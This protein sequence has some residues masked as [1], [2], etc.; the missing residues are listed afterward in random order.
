MWTCYRWPVTRK[1][2][3]IRRNAAGDI[4]CLSHDAKG[5]LTRSLASNCKKDIAQAS[6]KAKPRVCT[7][8]NYNTPLHWCA[9]NQA[10]CE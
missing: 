4:E 8:E 6:Y 7:A 10:E 2:I 9:V 1:F 5:C 3:P